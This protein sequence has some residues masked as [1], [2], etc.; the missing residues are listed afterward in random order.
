MVISIYKV[1]GGFR[2][3]LMDGPNVLS[4]SEATFFTRRDALLNWC[5][6]LDAVVESQIHEPNLKL[7][8]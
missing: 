1:R 5:R 6:I 3:R 8:K 4:R 2:W 7:V